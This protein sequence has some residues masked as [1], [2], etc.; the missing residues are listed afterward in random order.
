MCG[1]LLVRLSTY[2]SVSFEGEGLL[3][4]LWRKLLFPFV[5]LRM[6]LR[7]DFFATSKIGLEALELELGLY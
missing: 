5:E 1:L 7:L 4:G 6:I 3:E 2:H